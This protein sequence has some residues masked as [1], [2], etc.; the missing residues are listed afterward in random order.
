MKQN[1]KVAFFDID[2]TLASNTIV[3][4]N[5]IDRIPMS[6]RQAIKELKKNG[7]TPMIATGRGRIAV[8]SLVEALEMDSYISVNGQSIVYEGKEIHKQYLTIEEIE[9]ILKQTMGTFDMSIVLETTKGNVVVQL[10]ENERFR[11]ENYYADIRDNL[12]MIKEYDTYEVT[13]LGEEVKEKAIINIPGIK[14]KMVGIGAMNIYPENVSKATAIETVL[15]IFSLTKEQAIAFGDEEN[16]IDM[17]QAVGN[18]VAMG[19]ANEELKK[20]ATY[21][22]DTVDNNGIYKACQYYG[23]IK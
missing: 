21:V 3:S 10:S 17:F 8:T 12:T 5:I 15:E 9:A 18:A 16:D 4:K 6:A 19:N 1:I 11:A 20:L 2:G 14:G 22:S 7:I 23:L 13:L